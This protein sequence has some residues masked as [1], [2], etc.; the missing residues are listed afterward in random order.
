MASPG[1]KQDDVGRYA[2]LA[3]AHGLLY[4]A[5]RKN[6]RLLG[7]DPVSGAITESS[8]LPAGV[9]IRGVGGDDGLLWLVDYADNRRTLIRLRSTEARP[10]A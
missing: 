1:W 6:G 10:H 8:A 4:A 5:D 7:L 9:D 2:G 3:Y